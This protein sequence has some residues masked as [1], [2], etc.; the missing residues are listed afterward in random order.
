MKTILMKFQGPLQSYGTDSHFETRHTD[1][2]PSKG[3]V[4]GLIAAALGIR[5]EETAKLQELR[6]LRILF[7]VDQVGQM[8]KEFQIAAK[9]KKTGDHERNYVT[10]RYYLEDAAFLVAL[11]GEDDLTKRIYEALKRPYF[12][13]FY[14][15]RSCPVNYDFLLG[16]YEG[17]AFDQIREWP[18]IAADWYRKRKSGQEKIRLDV[19][20]DAACIPEE[21]QRALRRD[22]PISFSQMGRQHELRFESHK[23]IWIANPDYVTPDIQTE[24]DAFTALME[25]EYVSEQS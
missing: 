2:H 22:Q 5:R 15:R 3:A 17:A 23:S 9:Y 18:W 25:E 8:S 19:Y 21:S 24:H 11:E 1:D 14:G 13:L 10:Y 16:L 6:N 4:I 7:R 12:Q 20:G